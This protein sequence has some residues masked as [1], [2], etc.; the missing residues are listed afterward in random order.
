MPAKTYAEKLLDPRWQRKRLEILQR[1]DFTC[2]MCNSKDQT[3]HV[4]H[5]YY[6]KK[7]N[8]W[9]YD[10]TSLWTLCEHCHKEAAIHLVMLHEMIASVSPGSHLEMMDILWHLVHTY[11]GSMTNSAMGALMVS[12]WEEAETHRGRIAKG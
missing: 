9:E 2:V 3:L 1:D 6:D 4:H 12:A 5:G 7:L 11:H 10:S 8:P